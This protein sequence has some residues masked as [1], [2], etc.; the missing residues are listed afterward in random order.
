MLSVVIPTLNE[1]VNLPNLLTNLRHC[2]PNDSEIIVSDGSSTD[3]TV[4]LA[5]E[6]GCR[7]VVSK[8]RSPAIQRNRGAEMAKGDLLLFLDADTVFSEDVISK[9]LR[10]FE[11]KKLDVASYYFRFN[12][13][14][15]RYI[16]LFWYGTFLI[17]LLHFFHPVSIGAAILVKKTWFDKVGGFDEKLFVGED[18]LFAKRVQDAGGKYG[19]LNIPGMYF[20][21]RRFRKEGFW[22][23]TYKWH[24]FAYYYMRYGAFSKK[25]VPYEFGKYNEIL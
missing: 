12:S 8:S 2:V 3:N 10:M 6:S 13:P 23:V 14:K 4:I 11:E 9:T 17:Y 16:I 21:L 22:T 24:Y 20:S 25:I 15:L 7:V 1:A 18:H 5:R 19:L